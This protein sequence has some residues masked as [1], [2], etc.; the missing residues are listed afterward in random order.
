MKTT[1]SL[2]DH[3]DSI[4]F[5]ILSVSLK[6]T[7]KERVIA[8]YRSAGCQHQ[9]KTRKGLIQKSR[10]QKHHMRVYLLIGRVVIAAFTE[11]CERQNCWC[12]AVCSVIATGSRDR[13]TGGDLLL[14]Q[15]CMIVILLPCATWTLSVSWAPVVRGD[16]RLV[17]V[18]RHCFTRW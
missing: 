12:Q 11:F 18:L 13:R 3:A 15:C 1:F 7:L 9:K 14:A 10:Q 6:K 8:R 2:P 17:S 4:I 5:L 16:T